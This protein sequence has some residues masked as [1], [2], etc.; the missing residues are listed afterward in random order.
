LRRI[1]IDPDTLSSVDGRT[2]REETAQLRGATAHDPFPLAA[3]RCLGCG[4]EWAELPRGPETECPKCPSLYMKWLNY[5][6]DWNERTEAITGTPYWDHRALL[7]YLRERGR[8][9]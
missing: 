1:D 4:C 3:Y 8:R 7:G 6:D 5:S 2:T 9:G